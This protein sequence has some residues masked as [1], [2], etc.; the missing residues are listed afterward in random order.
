VAGV[1]KEAFTNPFQKAG[2]KQNPLCTKGAKILKQSLPF[3]VKH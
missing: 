3:W 2:L 1:D